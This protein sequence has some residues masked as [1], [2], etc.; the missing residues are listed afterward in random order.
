MAV[1][2]LFL[3]IGILLG[4]TTL[5][6]ILANV[7]VL[8][9]VYWNRSLQTQINMLLVNLAVADLGVAVSCVPFAITSVFLQ[10][11][12]SE[13]VKCQ[14]IVAKRNKLR[15]SEFKWIKLFLVTI[16]L[17]INTSL[18]GIT[19][20]NIMHLSLRFGIVRHR[21]FHFEDIFRMEI[22]AK[23]FFRWLECLSSTVSE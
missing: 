1:S 8:L 21:K 5:M 2:A 7:S 11:N 20:C 10:S 9:V 6:G 15:Y 13:I 14:V 16:S 4:L 18:N 23:I 3:T 17:T 12:V 19:D 22:G